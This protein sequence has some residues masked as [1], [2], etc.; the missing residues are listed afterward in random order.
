MTKLQF[1]LRLHE[2]LKALP[3]EESEER[4]NFFS[5]MIDDRMEEGLSEE[6][7]V[8]AVGN[9]EDIIS[10]ILANT[11]AESSKRQKRQ[12]RNQQKESQ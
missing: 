5:E 4:L 1:L 11:P 3:R 9:V 7:A 8:K 6:E 12:R 2:R 10:Q